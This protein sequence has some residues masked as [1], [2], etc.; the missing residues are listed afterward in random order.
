MPRHI[1]EI[2]TYVDAETF[3]DI[4]IALWESWCETHDLENVYNDI[5]KQHWPAEQVEQIVE[6]LKEP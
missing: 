1:I 3:K 4:V 6:D 2:E 5:T